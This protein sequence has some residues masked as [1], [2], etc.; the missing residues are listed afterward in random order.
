MPVSFMLRFYG[1]SVVTVV[2]SPR[3][4]QRLSATNCLHTQGS[5]FNS[6]KLSHN[7]QASMRIL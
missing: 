2:E 3:C 4:F 5:H 1:V 6:A 7:D